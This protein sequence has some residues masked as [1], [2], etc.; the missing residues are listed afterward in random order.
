MNTEKQAMV[1]FRSAQAHGTEIALTLHKQDNAAYAFPYS[2]LVAVEYNP[3]GKIEIYPTG[4]HVTIEGMNLD[5]IF[6]QL[7]N[8]RV[9]FFREAEHGA[10]FEAKKGEPFIE[11]IIVER[12]WHD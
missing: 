5:K 2:Y 4:Y 9:V 3:Q 1:G 6:P 10:E 12:I 8:Q 7:V 11:K